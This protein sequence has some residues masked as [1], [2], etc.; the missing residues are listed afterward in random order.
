MRENIGI[1]TLTKP[2]SNR[3]YA[4]EG[5]GGGPKRVPETE[6]DIMKMT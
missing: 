5:G 6:A 1:E 2:I 3:N 4:K